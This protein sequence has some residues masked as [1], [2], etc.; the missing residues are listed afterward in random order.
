MVNKYCQQIVRFC[1]HTK[2]PYTLTLDKFEEINSQQH[3]KQF[4]NKVKQYTARSSNFKQAVCVFNLTNV[5]KCK[6]ITT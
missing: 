2:Y 5:N 1:D 3:I 4:V 6:N